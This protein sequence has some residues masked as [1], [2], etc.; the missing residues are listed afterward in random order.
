MNRFYVKKENIIAGEIVI[1]DFADI[2]HMTRVLRLKE[3]SAFNVF[4]PLGWEYS[5][6]LISASSN[7]IRA[8]IVDKMKISSEPEVKIT[9]FQGVPKHGK[10]EN[11][12][13][14][15]VELG[16][17]RIVPVFTGRTVLKYSNKRDRWQKISEE[18]VKQC[19]RGIIPAVS[20]EMGFSEMVHELDQE[21]FDAVIFAY[22]NEEGRTL[23][24]ILK[25]C[26]EKPKTI[27]LIIGPEGGFSD[28]EACALKK[29]GA[30]SVS[31][32]KTL[33]RTETA[34]PAA[35]AM[36]MYEVEL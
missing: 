16:V 1:D 29:A 5:V 26:S 2:H 20:D 30:E 22:E 31:L 8:R 11:I 12:I 6:E 4:D 36:I 21:I 9:L 35:I 34:G 14:K 28:E 15:S 17:N 3:G 32:G 18:A 13:Q 33:L 25:N 27:A 24:D 7:E 23:K 10:M 19:R